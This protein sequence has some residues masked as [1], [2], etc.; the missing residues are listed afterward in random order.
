MLKGIHQRFVF[1]RIFFLPFIF[2]CLLVSCDS[3][4]V[5]EKNREVPDGVWDAGKSVFFEVRISD[6]V[7]LHNLFINLRNSGDFRFSNIYLFMDIF[8]PDGKIEHD[9]V[10][11]ILAD[12]Q[13]RWLG[14]SGTG[15]I[16]ENRILFSRKTRFPKPGKY[17]FRINQAMR[18]KKLEHIIDVGLRIEK[19][20]E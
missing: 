5:F 1:F 2:I 9:T 4:M 16:W 15:S 7:S 12:P 13:G 3:K 8:Q 18:E 20:Y 11:C 19:I 10:E 14:K 17:V 6:T